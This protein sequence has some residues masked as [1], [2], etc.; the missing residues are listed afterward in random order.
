MALVAVVVVLVVTVVV[1]VKV[2]TG[3][4]SGHPQGAV[5]PPITKPT[6]TPDPVKAAIVQA[7]KN[8]TDAFVHAA[9]TGNPNDP[10]VAATALGVAEVTETLNLQKDVA[11]HIISRGSI[12]IGHP[13]VESISSVPGT[14]N[15]TAQ[16]SDCVQD[17]LNGYNV[18][19]GVPVN[20]QTGLPLPPGQTPGPPQ[21]E[22]I[23]ATLGEVGGVWKLL[24]EQLTVVASC[25]AG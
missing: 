20:A 4:G 15:S 2:L 10:A 11:L 25:P 14:P 12:K 22:R 18:Q 21:A 24:D 7:Y 8:A 17:D 1:G 23:V 3:S 13:R 16:L 19:T 6:P 5:A 9:T